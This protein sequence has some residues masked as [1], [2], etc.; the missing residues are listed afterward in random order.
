MI[1][2]GQKVQ[3]RQ[4]P[5]PRIVIEPQH[6]RVRCQIG[7][8]LRNRRQRRAARNPHQHPLDRGAAPRP[9]LGVGRIDLDRAVDALGVEVAGDEPRADAL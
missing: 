9:L 5:L 3:H 7:Q 8:F 4:I 2:F 1:S 6:P